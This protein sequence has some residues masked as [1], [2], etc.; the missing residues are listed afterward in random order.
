MIIE[1]AGLN[2]CIQSAYHVKFYQVSGPDWLVA[3]RY[4]IMA[5]TDA[6]ASKEQLMVMLQALLTD[7]F[8]LR[9]HRETRT[10]SVYELVAKSQAM[11]L[12]RAS[13][14]ETGQGMT[15]ENGSFVFRGVTMA[16]FAE[17]L[18]DFSSFDRPVLDRT[19]MDGLFDITLPSAA[20]AMRSDPDAIF[21]AVEGAGFRLNSAKAPLEMLVV[22]HAERPSPN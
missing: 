20:T 5:K 13:S 22:D 2:F 19:G 3:E 9:L 18:S 7:R 4:D 17:R 8:S 15:V 1:N 6:R 10:V 21:A 14:D 11:K 12:N 16:E